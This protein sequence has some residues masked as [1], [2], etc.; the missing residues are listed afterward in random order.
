MKIRTKQAEST[1]GMLDL[2]EKLEEQ[3]GIARERG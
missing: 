2:A 1:K 3:Q